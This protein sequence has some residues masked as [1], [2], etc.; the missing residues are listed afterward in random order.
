MELACCDGGVCCVCSEACKKDPRCEFYFSIDS[1][2]ALTNP[3]T[4]RILI[5][6]NKSVLPRA[7]PPAGGEAAGAPLM[8]SSLQVRHRAHVVQTREA[9]EQLLGGAESRGLLLQI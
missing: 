8:L 1:D 2:V 7:A 4:L 3:D 5:E 6:E 9:V